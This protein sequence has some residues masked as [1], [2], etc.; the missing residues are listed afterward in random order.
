M[1]FIFVTIL[2]LS[3]GQLF[4]LKYS[5]TDEIHATFAQSNNNTSISVP[6]N[7]NRMEITLKNDQSANPSSLLDSPLLIAAI[8]AG[9]AIVGGLTGSYMTNRSN[10]QLDDE[11]YKREREREKKIREEEEDK[12]RLYKDKVTALIYA[13]LSNFSVTL[14]QLQDENVWKDAKSLEYSKML[15]SLVESYKFEFLKLPFD[16]RLTLFDIVVLYTV[17]TAYDAVG[18]FMRSFMLLLQED[19]AVP[20]A[21]LKDGVEKLAP[22]NIKE[23]VDQ[24]VKELERILPKSIVDKFKDQ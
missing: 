5:L 4:S 14:E 17:Q 22:W 20:V 13:E 19:E 24:A 6:S 9:S 3:I 15:K 21:K 7:M 2:I 10:R 11:R 12:K 1:Y 8:S 23:L 16:V 18:A